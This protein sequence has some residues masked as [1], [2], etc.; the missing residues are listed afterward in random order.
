MTPH[1]SSLLTFVVLDTYD[2]SEATPLSSDILRCLREVPRRAPQLW[3]TKLIVKKL[4]VLSREIYTSYDYSFYH[5]CQTILNATL[6]LI[7]YALCK[8]RCYI[9]DLGFTLRTVLTEAEVSAARRV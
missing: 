2:M 6:D 9:I 1:L 3:W 8:G 4:P 7:D 5:P